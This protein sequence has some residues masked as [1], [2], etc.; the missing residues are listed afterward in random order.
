MYEIIEI[1]G[2]YKIRQPNG[3]FVRTVS[4][5]VWVG[6]REEAERMMTILHR[7]RE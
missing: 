5:E 3:K 4:G 2:G 6:I 1:P 7:V